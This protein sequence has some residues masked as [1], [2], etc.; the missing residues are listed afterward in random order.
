MT[1][2]G[3]FQTFA[4]TRPDSAVV[5]NPDLIRARSSSWE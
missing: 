3:E 5:P 2:S 4:N 1:S